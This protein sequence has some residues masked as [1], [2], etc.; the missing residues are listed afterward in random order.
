MLVGLFLSGC[1]PND[2]AYPVNL[3][4]EGIETTVEL[5]IQKGGNYVICLLFDRKSGIGS[6]RKYDELLL[7]KNSVETAVELAL[8]SEDFFYSSNSIRKDSN[9]SIGL[10]LDGREMYG[11]FRIDKNVA[12]KPGKYSLRYMNKRKIPEIDGINAYVVL[13]RYEP[14]I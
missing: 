6:T 14:K 1:T 4:S 10:K 2:F 5:N 11:N 8:S 3:A 7:G 12:L 9:G 13:F